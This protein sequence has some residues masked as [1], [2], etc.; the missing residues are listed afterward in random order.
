MRHRSTNHA[1]FY[2]PTETMKINNKLTFKERYEAALNEPTP[3]AAWVAMIAKITHRSET[4]VR[5]WL[6]GKQNPDELAKAVVADH[7]GSTVATLFPTNE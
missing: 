1:S 4:T 5:M 3:A 2:K 7:F 6:S